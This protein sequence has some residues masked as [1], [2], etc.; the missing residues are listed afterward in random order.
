MISPLRNSYGTTLHSYGSIYY[1]STR[2]IAIG[3]AAY[4]FLMKFFKA[5]MV[6]GFEHSL[7]YSS[8]PST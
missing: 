7:N 3:I 4:S 2:I 8:S 5:A 6:L 1:Y